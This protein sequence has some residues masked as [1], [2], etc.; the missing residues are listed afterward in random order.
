MLAPLAAAAALTVWAAAKDNPIDVNGAATNRAVAGAVGGAPDQPDQRDV[1]GTGAHSEK[2]DMTKFAEALARIAERAS[3]HDEETDKVENDEIDDS[4]LLAKA[5]DGHY[6]SAKQFVNRFRKEFFTIASTTSTEE[7]DRIMKE[8]L[9]NMGA[10]VDI[11]GKLSNMIIATE[12]YRKLRANKSEFMNAA[13]YHNDNVT[14]RMDGDVAR[15]YKDMLY[16]RLASDLVFGDAYD[17][18]KLK[19]MNMDEA[20]MRAFAQE[21]VDYIEQNVSHDYLDPDI[22]DMLRRRYGLDR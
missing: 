8:K 12:N 16:T 20:G 13:Q 14:S 10:D 2:P 1:D 17:P 3:G 15:G 19:M 5:L 9:K 18:I 22:M 7:A 11:D 21:T 4:E 6:E